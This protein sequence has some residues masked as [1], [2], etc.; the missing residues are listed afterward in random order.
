M[1]REVSKADVTEEELAVESES[2]AMFATFGDCFDHA[3]TNPMAPATA[4]HSLFTDI[5]ADGLPD[6]APIDLPV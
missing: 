4:A 1:A 5:W 6:E 3:L 2:S